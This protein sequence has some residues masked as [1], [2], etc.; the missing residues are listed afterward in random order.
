MDNNKTRRY[1][2][3]CTSA[4]CAN[5]KSDPACIACPA[6]PRLDAWEAWVIETNARPVDPIW[7]PNLYVAQR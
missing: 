6:R 3:A 4:Y 1:P 2:S 5:V 7:S